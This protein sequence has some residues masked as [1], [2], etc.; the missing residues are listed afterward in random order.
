MVTLFTGELKFKIYVNDDEPPKIT[1]FNAEP[2]GNI[3]QERTPPYVDATTSPKPDAVAI[4]PL[5]VV[6]EPNPGKAPN[7]G[8]TAQTGVGVGV[9]IGRVGV[10]VGVTTSQG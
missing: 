1:V 9:G 7:V 2:G 3:H 8:H 10:G 6:E 4:T 5:I